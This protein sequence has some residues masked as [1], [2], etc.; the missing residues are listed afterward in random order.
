ML[1]DCTFNNGL[2]LDDATKIQHFKSGIRPEAG[3]EVALTTSR[4][5]PTYRGFDHLVSFLSAEV[6]Q[7]MIRGQQVSTASNRRVSSANTGRSVKPSANS[8]KQVESCVVDGKRVY[9]KSYPKREFRSLTKPQREAVIRMH[10]DHR[11]NS[12]GRGVSA[13]R[14]RPDPP[15]DSPDIQ[16]SS[17]KRKAEA[18]S[19]GDFIHNRRSKK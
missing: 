1:Q 6:D 2:G 15:A 10:K 17:S 12:Q 7:K 5:N 13:V 19:I 11:V 4:S 14:E 8:D 9:R 18:G 3:L 16:P